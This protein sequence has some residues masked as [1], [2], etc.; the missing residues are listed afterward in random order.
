MVQGISMVSFPESE[1]DDDGGGAGG[2]LIE[3]YLPSADV[4]DDVIDSL[5]Y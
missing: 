5:A 4:I 3:P 1:D 2:S